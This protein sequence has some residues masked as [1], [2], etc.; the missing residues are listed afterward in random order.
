M[1]P[2]PHLNFVFKFITP[3]KLGKFQVHK[4]N[5]AELGNLWPFSIRQYKLSVEK[6]TLKP[7]PQDSHQLTLPK[8]KY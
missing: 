6:I 2:S 5:C 1:Q 7:I 4:L 8:H 3:E